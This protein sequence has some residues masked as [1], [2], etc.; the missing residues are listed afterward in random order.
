MYLQQTMKI[1]PTEQLYYILAPFASMCLGVNTKALLT[2]SIRRQPTVRSCH[3][4]NND[5]DLGRPSYKGAS[6]LLYIDR[7]LTSPFAAASG[8][9][10]GD[11]SSIHPPKIKFAGKTITFNAPPGA[12]KTEKTPIRW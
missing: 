3:H 8:A 4:V 9:S 10:P 12:K 6:I 11:T 1:H 5:S 2:V 7:S